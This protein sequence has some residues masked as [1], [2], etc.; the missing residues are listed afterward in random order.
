MFKA[1]LHYQLCDIRLLTSSV[2]SFVHCLSFRRFI[3]GRMQAGG[4]KMGYWKCLL[5]M[6]KREEE[7]DS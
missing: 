2:I 5:G 3:V 6:N 1:A 7:D 4:R